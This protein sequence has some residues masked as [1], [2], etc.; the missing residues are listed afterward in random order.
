MQYFADLGLEQVSPT[1]QGIW[2][3]QY[4]WDY[5]QNTDGTKIAALWLKQTDGNQS[6][7]VRHITPIIT[8]KDDGTATIVWEVKWNVSGIYPAAFEVTALMSDQVTIPA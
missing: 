8:T 2:I 5:L 1:D 3:V 4:D 6:I 7:N